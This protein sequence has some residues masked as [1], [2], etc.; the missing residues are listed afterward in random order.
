MVK[1]ISYTEFYVQREFLLLQNKANGN[2]NE[3]FIHPIKSESKILE[4]VDIVF[5]IFTLPQLII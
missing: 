1:H 3:R 4:T 5:S 2:S